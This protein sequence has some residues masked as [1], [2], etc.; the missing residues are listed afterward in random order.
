MMTRVKHITPTVE[1]NF[2]LRCKSQV[3]VIIVMRT[4]LLKEL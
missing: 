1:L 4:Y 2:R 3:Y